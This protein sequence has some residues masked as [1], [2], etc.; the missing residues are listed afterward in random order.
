MAV[1]LLLGACAGQLQ[2]APEAMLVEGRGKG[3]AAQTAGVTVIARARAWQSS[4][5]SLEL[6]VT[7]IL[8]TIENESPTPLRVRYADFAL[9]GPEGRRFAARAPFEVQG[10][11]ADPGAGYAYPR[12]PYPYPYFIRDSLGRPV[13][14]DPFWYDPFYDFG[15]F[16]SVSLPTGDMVQLALP[17]RVVEPHGRATGFVYFERVQK[18][19]RVDFTARLLDDRSGQ[20]IGTVT[21]PFVLD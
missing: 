2:P 15:R 5:S 18:V 1:S 11:V 19:P 13:A 14:F 3:A 8:V 4:P 12:Y 20:P 6:V 17:E 9:V 21:I 10:Y 16:P 7:P